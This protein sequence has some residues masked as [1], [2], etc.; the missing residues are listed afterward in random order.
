MEVVSALAVAVP[1]GYTELAVILLILLP[2]L[3]ILS[4]IHSLE[5]N[6]GFIGSGVFLYL[7]A[8]LGDLASG[9]YAVVGLVCA[10]LSV[11]GIGIDLIDA[12]LHV[13]ETDLLVGAMLKGGF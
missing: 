3:S 2:S 5:S 1:S 10:Y 6:L 7:L 8:T 13:L 4:V 11:L 12:V 9:D